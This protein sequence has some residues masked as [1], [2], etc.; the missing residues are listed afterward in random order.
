MSKTA[1]RLFGPALL[2]N[3]ATTKYTAPTGGKAVLRQLHVSNPSG[4]PATLTVSHG[5]DAAGVRIFDAY[6]IASGS[7]FDWYGYIIIESAEVVQAF[8][9]TNNAMT[10][11]GYGDELTAG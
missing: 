10:L 5:A 1:K 2:S 11:T 6:S 9:G 8:S 4:S 3:A 7:V